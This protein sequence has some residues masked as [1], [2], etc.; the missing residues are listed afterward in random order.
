ML[1]EARGG[2]VGPELEQRLVGDRGG[3]SN[4]GSGLGAESGW[5]LGA[6]GEEEQGFKC[7]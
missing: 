3:A 4:N 6:N 1:R 5:F 7:A 2:E